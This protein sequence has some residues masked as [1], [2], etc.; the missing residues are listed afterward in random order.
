MD[1][2]DAVLWMHAANQLNFF[3]F[4]TKLQVKGSEE[5]GNS[6]IFNLLDWGGFRNIQVG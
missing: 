1:G 6:Q 4:M 5:A 2:N 3:I